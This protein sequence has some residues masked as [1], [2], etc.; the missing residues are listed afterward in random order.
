MS[1]LTKELRALGPV[2]LSTKL[3]ELHKELIK[4]NAQVAT[5]TAIKS[6]GMV[7]KTKK[8]IARIHLILSEKKTKEAK[9]SK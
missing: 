5:G 2:E 4:L 1:K 3:N 9:K 6:P 8:T 7:K